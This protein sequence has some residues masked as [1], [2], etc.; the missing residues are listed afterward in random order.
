MVIITSNN[1]D[2]SANLIID[3]LIKY[4]INFLRLNSNDKLKLSFINGETYIEHSQ[5]SFTIN[6]IKGVF[7]RGSWFYFND[8]SKHGYFK[9]EY[10]HLIEYVIFS[11]NKKTKCLFK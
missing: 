8:P 7:N 4:N 11:L 5:C 6:E 10:R 1:T 2:K 9:N 3:W